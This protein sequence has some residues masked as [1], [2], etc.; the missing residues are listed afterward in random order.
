MSQSSPFE[1]AALTALYEAHFADRPEYRMGWSFMYCP[2]ARLKTA[3]LGIIGLNPGGDDES[4]PGQAAQAYWDWDDDGLAYVDQ[5]WG[6]NGALNPLQCQIKL[7]LEALSVD[8]SEVFAAQLVPFRSQ[9]WNSL[10]DPHAAVR[11][12]RPLWQHIGRVSPTIKLWISLGKK[13][14]RELA[15]LLQ[16]S[17]TRRLDVGWRRHFAELYQAPDGRV[18]LALPH[19][20][21]F[22]LLSTEDRTEILACLAEAKRLSGLA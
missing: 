14:G 2:E 12:C 8:S 6:A 22:K 3:R 10:P 20:S 1:K 4:S 9:S 16:A 19:L 21:R 7:L 13:A 5:P 15:R 17:G 11:A 18:V